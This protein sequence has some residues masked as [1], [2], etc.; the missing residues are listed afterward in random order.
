MPELYNCT[1]AITLARVVET[2]RR[3]RRALGKR[4]AAPV[5]PIGNA[6]LL[7]ML[8]LAA[9]RRRGSLHPDCL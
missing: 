4:Q 2:K 1:H 9:V 5:A 6:G 7:S 8:P 3:A